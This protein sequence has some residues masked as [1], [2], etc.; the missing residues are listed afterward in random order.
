MQRVSDLRRS[1]GHGTDH[2][3]V[4]GQQLEATGR[5]A[6]R[7]FGEEAPLRI[8]HQPARAS[9]IEDHN[10]AIRG[11]PCI[12]DQADFAGSLAFAADGAQKRARTPEQL[13]VSAARLEDAV[14]ARGRVMENLRAGRLDHPLA[15]L[16]TESDDPLRL[17]AAR[18]T[19]P[20]SVG[21]DDRLRPERW[22]QDG[23]QQDTSRH[24]RHG[25]PCPRKDRP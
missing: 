5:D 7:A 11:E 6:G 23:Q 21:R 14:R 19:E 1:P 10:A 15:V 17:E 25:S 13:N 16:V 9:I 12:D 18:R 2:R 22:W 3:R 20:E 4:G 24:Q 8:E